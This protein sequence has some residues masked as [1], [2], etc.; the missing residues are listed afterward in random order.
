MSYLWQVLSNTKWRL[1]VL[2][3]FLTAIPTFAIVDNITVIIVC[4]IFATHLSFF[5][6]IAVG[7]ADLKRAR[8]KRN[9]KASCS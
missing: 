7:Y 5:V 6:A 2:A 9:E 8:A 1:A 3:A 4:V